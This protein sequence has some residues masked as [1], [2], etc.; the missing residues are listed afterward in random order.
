MRT[1]TS[2]GRATLPPRR[3]RAPHS[4]IIA[5]AA[6]GGRALAR[7]AQPGRAQ[8]GVATNGSVG[9]LP[10]TAPRQGLKI[11]DLPDAV[12]AHEGDGPA[13]PVR[14]GRAVARLLDR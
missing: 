4:Y 5:G 12:L 13:G 14:H 6:G 3:P 7:R 2:S 11:L 10:L 8:P 1:R 9:A